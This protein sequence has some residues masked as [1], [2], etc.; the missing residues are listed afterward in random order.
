VGDG[1]MCVDVVGIDELMHDLDFEPSLLK[2][3]VEGMEGALLQD[4]DP[5]WITQ[6]S[7]IIAE[8]HAEYC[9]VFR[10]IEIV[11]QLGFTYYPP[12]RLRNG[13][14]HRALREGLFVRT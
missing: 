7:E 6:F 3:D 5:V 2:I 11:R 9:D 1:T 4:I 14:G 8:L 12:H 13:I 10:L